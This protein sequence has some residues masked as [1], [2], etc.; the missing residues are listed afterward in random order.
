MC[1][2]GL[3]QNSNFGALA[4]ALFSLS[5]EK[6]SDLTLYLTQLSVAKQKCFIQF[7][8]AAL[9]SVWVTL[10]GEI[11]IGKAKLLHNE[12]EMFTVLSQEF[13]N[14][15]HCYIMKCWVKSGYLWF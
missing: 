9:R 11:D 13:R 1:Y 3:E 2:Q 4:V 6:C 8:L 12:D 5:S 10:K 14:K 15:S 7:Y